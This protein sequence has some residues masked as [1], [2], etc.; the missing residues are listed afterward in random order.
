MKFDGGTS[1]LS[2]TMF[3]VNMMTNTEE[4]NCYSRQQ[5]ESWLSD[6]SFEPVDFFALTARAGVL[7]A[8]K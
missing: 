3:A 1:P 2:S 7:I 5:V 6:T 8:K 4:G